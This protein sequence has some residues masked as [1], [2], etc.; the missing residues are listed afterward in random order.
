MKEI[1]RQRTEKELRETLSMIC[2]FVWYKRLRVGDHLWSIPVDEER[3][4]DCIL[5]DAITEL[6]ELRKATAKEPAA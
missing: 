6:V 2:H 1:Y 5:S 3:D 4:F